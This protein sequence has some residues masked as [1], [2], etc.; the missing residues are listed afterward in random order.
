MPS[1]LRDAVLS[2]ADDSVLEPISDIN[3][4]YATQQQLALLESVGQES[5]A[6][7]KNEQL[8][9]I[10]R[11]VGQNREQPRIK[12]FTANKQQALQSKAM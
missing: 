8:L 2:S 5:L 3:R 11:S 10:A 1:Q 12:M 4:E 9:K 7:A 6:E